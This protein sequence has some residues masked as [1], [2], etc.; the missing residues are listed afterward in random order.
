MRLYRYWQRLDKTARISTTPTPPQNSSALTNRRHFLYP[1]L[2]ILR[3]RHLR[4]HTTQ[5]L[6]LQALS[7]LVRHTTTTADINNTPP[8]R[9]LLL[10]AFLGV[11]LEHHD[12][13]IDIQPLQVHA[14][15]ISHDAGIQQEFCWHQPIQVV[16]CWEKKYAR[17]ARSFNPISSS[18]FAGSG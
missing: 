12:R 8:R 14:Q 4:P 15:D 11:G 9:Q 3:Y 13:D 6:P 5:W 18:T 16:C 10:P 17:M 1:Y 2:R 7:F